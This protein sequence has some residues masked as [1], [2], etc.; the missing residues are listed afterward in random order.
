MLPVFAAILYLSACTKTADSISQPESGDI[1]G[2]WN[3][4]S[5]STFKGV[6]SSN[7]PVDYTGVAGDYFNFL[8]NGHAYSKEGPVL[9]TLMYTLVSDNSIIISGF[10]VILNGVQDTSVITGLT[11]IVGSAQT[12][13]IASSLALTPGGEFWRKVTLSR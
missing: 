3:L 6:G 13:T 10:G 12:I 2:K 8:S 4:V 9:D 1:T 5:D 11:T 7:H